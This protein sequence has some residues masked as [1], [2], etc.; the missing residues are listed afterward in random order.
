V[1][2]ELHLE[3]SCHVPVL[4]GSLAQSIP[5]ATFDMQCSTCMLYRSHTA[6]DDEE[7]SDTA[8]SSGS[9]TSESHQHEQ[10]QQ[11]MSL[12]KPRTAAAGEEDSITSCQPAPPASVAFS[13]GSRPYLTPDLTAVHCWDVMHDILAAV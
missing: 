7:T 5:L 11:R 2:K 9:D 10:Q 8:T 3:G 13:F 4:L 12:R 1:P 6:G